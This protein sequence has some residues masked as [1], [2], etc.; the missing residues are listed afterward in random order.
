MKKAIKVG[1]FAF[2]A[3]ALFFGIKAVKQSGNCEL[4]MVDDESAGN[5]EA[6]EAKR[7]IMREMAS[8][9]GKKSKRG[10]AKKKETAESASEQSDISA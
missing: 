5:D 4:E 9:G 3:I 2:A 8:K 7:K 6:A 10:P 1:G